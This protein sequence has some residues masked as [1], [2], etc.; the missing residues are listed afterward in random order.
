M[1]KMLH[2]IFA[3]INRS[4]YERF[5]QASNV[6][7]AS[8]SRKRWRI[9]RYVTVK[10]TGKKDVEY[11]YPEGEFL[12]VRNDQEATYYKVATHHQAWKAGLLRKS[13]QRNRVI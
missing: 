3:Q 13:G 11:P 1:P 2:W 8:K 4:N 5:M 7:D 10:S 6:L 9:S 12:L